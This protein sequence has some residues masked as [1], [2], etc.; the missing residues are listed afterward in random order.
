MVTKDT[1]QNSGT[2]A[3][4]SAT[5]IYM[6]LRK[7]PRTGFRDVSDDTMLAGGHAREGIEDRR[8]FLQAS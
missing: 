6:S 3:P 1:V 2:V 7:A 4:A 8:L 5:S